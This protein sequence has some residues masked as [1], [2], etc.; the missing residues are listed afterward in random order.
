MPK[1]KVKFS[2]FA[3]VDAEDPK[4]AAEE[5]EDLCAYME[6]SV[7]SVEEVDEFTVSI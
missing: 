4:E 6:T 3:Y 2:G 7:D 1:Y 5:Y